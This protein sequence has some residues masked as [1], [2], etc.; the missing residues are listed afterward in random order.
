MGW[1]LLAMG[2]ATILT[3]PAWAEPA[4]RDAIDLEAE[5]LRVRIER[6]SEKT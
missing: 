3:L 1:L 4:W 6:E 5:R 2:L